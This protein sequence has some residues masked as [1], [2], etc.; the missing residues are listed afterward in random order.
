MESIKSIV[1]FESAYALLEYVYGT[2]EIESGMT[3]EQIDLF[4]CLNDYESFQ[5]FLLNENTV[6]VTESFGDVS[7][8]PM[9]IYQFY[10]ETVSYVK[11]NA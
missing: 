10:S 9:P 1:A 3:E 11:E 5:F 8:E 4:K 2:D 6:I 7:G